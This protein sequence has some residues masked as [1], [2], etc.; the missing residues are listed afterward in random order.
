M[1]ILCNQTFD[2]SDFCCLWI[3]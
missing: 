3:V 1:P 2:V